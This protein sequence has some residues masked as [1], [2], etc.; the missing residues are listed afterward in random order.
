MLRITLALLLLPAFAFG[1]DFVDNDVDV[2][3]T[4]QQVDL[5]T[6]GY[7]YKTLWY[8]NDGLNE[9]FVCPWRRGETIIACT[10]A[11]GR[12]IEAG[13][14]KAWTVS[15]QSPN[16]GGTTGARHGFIAF[17]VICSAT[18]TSDDNRTEGFDPF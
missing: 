10:A 16:P 9:V 8:K 14:A 13:E 17:T 12:R 5:A 7:G 4:S 1:A 6:T 15:G 18:E 11:I 3:A 2:T